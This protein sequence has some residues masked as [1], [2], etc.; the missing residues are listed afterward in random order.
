MY[1]QEE[2]MEVS[3]QIKEQYKKIPE[4]PRKLIFLAISAARATHLTDMNVV[5]NLDDLQRELGFSKTDQYAELKETVHTA[6][7]Q[8]LQYESEK[9]IG[10]MPFLPYCRLDLDKNI[11]IVMVNQ[12]LFDLDINIDGVFEA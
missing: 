12:Y 7:N 3:E 11:L 6:Y 9:E 1:T 5:F 2:V 10:Q 4:M 8:I